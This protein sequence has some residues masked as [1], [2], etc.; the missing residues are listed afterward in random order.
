[1]ED[2]KKVKIGVIGCGMISDA[3]LNASKMFEILDVVACTDMKMENAKEKAEKYSIKAL[4][5]DD[6][7]SRDDIEIVINLTPP[8]AH[9]DVTMAILKAGKH[10][11]SEK[12]F[13]INFEEAAELTA[14]AKKQGLM[15]GS[16]PD[17]FFGGGLQTAR[18]MLDDGW[19]GKPL[20]GTAMVMGR[21]PEKWPHAPAFYDIGAGP[22]L[23]LGPYYITALVHL[24]GPA[25]SVTAVTGKGSP[26]RVGGPDTVPRIYPIN[27]DTHL[28]GI[29][30]FECGATIT[31]I[32]SFEV[33][34]NKHTPIEIYGDNGSLCVPDPNTFKGPVSVFK[35]GYSDWQDVPLSHAYTDNSRSIGVADMAC[36]LRSGRKFRANSELATHVLEIMLAFEKSGKEEKKVTLSTT[37]EQP[38][39]LPLG[40]RDGNLD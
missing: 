13:G 2:L 21:G 4:S 1:M 19:I 37:C 26:T 5:M 29:V 34:K 3:Y 10:A 31:V 7:L 27:V 24:L 8:K 11:Y 39:A 15:L 14:F 9:Y 22:M 20:A 12:P 36:A 23:D 35:P 38:E 30:E 16:A 18:K 6:L 28:T 33:Y 25:K 32:A 40:L 17:T